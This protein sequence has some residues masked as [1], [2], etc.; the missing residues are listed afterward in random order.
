MGKYTTTRDC[1]ACGGTNDTRICDVT[2]PLGTEGLA[3]AETSGA[4]TWCA[5]CRQAAN[6]EGFQV[7]LR[8]DGGCSFWECARPSGHV[9]PC[10]PAT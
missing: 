3:F 9:G 6:V 8:C 2:N 4:P 10:Y 7:S 1:E 5:S